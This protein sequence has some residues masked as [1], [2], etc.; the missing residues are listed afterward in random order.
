MQ[1]KQQSNLKPNIIKVYDKPKLEFVSDYEES[2][3]FG[4]DKQANDDS[5]SSSSLSKIDLVGSI[6]SALEH[7]GQASWTLERQEQKRLKILSR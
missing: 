1:P 5:V 2:D 6:N 4:S 7:E 3:I